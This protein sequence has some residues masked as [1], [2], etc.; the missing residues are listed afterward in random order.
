ML[1]IG[2]RSDT[3]EELANRVGA[4]FLG[5]YFGK[6]DKPKAGWYAWDELKNQT[7]KTILQANGSNQKR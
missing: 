5:V 1:F 7:L 2:D 3:D 4:R 6:K